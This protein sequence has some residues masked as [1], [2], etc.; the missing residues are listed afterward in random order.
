MTTPSDKV[1]RQRLAA[2]RYRTRHL[3]E[4]RAKERARYAER[5]E[6]M[7]AA[8]REQYANNREARIASSKKWQKAHP[9]HVKSVYRRYHLM[10]YY[11][12][13]PEEF[14]L[15]FLSQ[16]KRCA[17]CKNPE[18][19][20]KHPWHIDHSHT[21]GAV[22]GILCSRCNLLL[23]HAKDNVETLRSAIAYLGS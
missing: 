14:D 19:D 12:M 1:Y 7:T 3:E 10:K 21:T 15:L 16:D 4:V 6:E 13:T 5:R 8:K 17:I 18:P 23:G 2:K 20:G 11:D 9:E 22:R